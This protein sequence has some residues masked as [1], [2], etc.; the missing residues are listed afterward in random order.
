MGVISLMSYEILKDIILN[1]R[2]IRKFKD[3]PVPKE[4]IQELIE[5]ARWAPSDTNMQPWKF[6]IISNK[7]IIKKIEEATVSGMTELQAKAEEIGRP[8]VKR[9]MEIFS[10]YALV[11]KNAPTV[12]ICLSEPYSSKFTDDIFTPI[13]HGMDMWKEE[14]IKSTCLAAQNIMLAAHSLG[15][16]TCAMSGPMILA[17]QK[18]KEALNIEE[19]YTIA[20]VIAL[21]VPEGTVNAPL[22]KG[23]EQI[24][25]YID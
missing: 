23:I 21:G 7:D 5:C 16:G 17:E 18:L 11:F 20:L 3:E 24:F 2:S 10:K 4:K 1:R 25:E 9:K 12:I 22:R 19:K 13:N 15:Y 14:G 8:D 6:I